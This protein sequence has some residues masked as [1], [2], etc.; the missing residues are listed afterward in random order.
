MYLTIFVA[1]AKISFVYD[2][3]APLNTCNTQN[4][5]RIKNSAAG[6]L[7]VSISFI[8]DSAYYFVQ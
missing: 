4:K 8:L 7:S 6:C 3:V 1:D 2:F 5:D